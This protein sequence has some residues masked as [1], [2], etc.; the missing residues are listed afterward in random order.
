MIDFDKNE[1]NSMKLIAVRGNTTIDVTTRFIKRK[2]LMFAKMSIKS[3]VY[4]LIEV[5]CF[6]IEEVR[7]IYDQHD[8]IKCHINLNL[9]DT[10]S[11]SMFFKIFMIL[12]FFLRYEKVKKEMGL[13]EIEKFKNRTVNKKH[14]GVRRDTPGMIFESYAKRIKVLRQVDSK[15]A[16]KK[17]DSKKITS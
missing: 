11:C 17:N 1:C 14:K 10:D 6:L 15:H 4:D 3:F 13:Y 7:R 2:M 12:C 16:N 8:I 5:F 9:T